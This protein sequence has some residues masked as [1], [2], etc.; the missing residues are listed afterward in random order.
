MRSNRIS[1]DFPPSLPHSSV[2]LYLLPFIYLSLGR[3][4][5]KYYIITRII[6]LTI[7]VYYSRASAIEA[8]RSIHDRAHPV[9]YLRSPRP[10]R[11]GA[12]S[13]TSTS[14]AYATE[15][16]VIINP[17]DSTLIALAL[18]Y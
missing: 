7:S 18:S 12:L 9:V 14:H 3:E 10:R 8:D 13:A 4:R 6:M 11:G 2:F 1:R 15:I 16:H 17:L 5:Y